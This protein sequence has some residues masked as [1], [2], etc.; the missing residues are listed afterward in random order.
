[1]GRD[2]SGSKERV[3]KIFCNAAGDGD[4]KKCRQLSIVPIISGTRKVAGKTVTVHLTPEPA[5]LCKQAELLPRLVYRK[6]MNYRTRCIYDIYLV[7]VIIVFE[8]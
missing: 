3:S 5:D 2:V 8:R 4:T 6:A 1:M 7:A